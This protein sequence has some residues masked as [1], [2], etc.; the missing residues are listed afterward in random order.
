MA[1]RKGL[2]VWCQSTQLAN[3]DPEK[4]P[5]WKRGCPGVQGKEEVTGW[6][7]RRASGLEGALMQRAGADG[8]GSCSGGSLL[9]HRHLHVHRHLN[10]ILTQDHLPQVCPTS[11]SESPPVS[12]AEGWRYLRLLSALTS[13]FYQLPSSLDFYPLV[14]KSYLFSQFPLPRLCLKFNIFI[15]E[16]NDWNYIIW[17][18]NQCLPWAYKAAENVLSLRDTVAN[19]S[20]MTPAL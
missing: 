5:L 4:A 1:G 9:R 14:L 11:L 2:R 7:K 15:G 20:G 16:K 19:K 3:L 8:I 13:G 17:S 6:R 10:L 12:K 18:L